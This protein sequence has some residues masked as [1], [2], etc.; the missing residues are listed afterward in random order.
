MSGEHPPGRADTSGVH[1]HGGDDAAAVAHARTLYLDDQHP[2]GCAETSYV[3]LLT[4]FGLDPGNAGAAMALNGG[5]AYSGGPCGALTG[6]AIAVGMLAERRISDH[7]RAKRVAREVVAEAMARF[8]LE[9]GAV[10]CR[11]LIGVDLQAPGG[12]DA[13][14]ASGAWRDGCL[15]QI[16]SVVRR[17]APLA[18][19]GIWDDTVREIEARS[20][21]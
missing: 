7:A 17:L 10:D 18:D 11:D 4:A 9:H 1:G 3:V 2:Y 14:L 6:A 16:E 20:P 8:R 5:I 12:H 15:R 21:D 13:F 19:Q